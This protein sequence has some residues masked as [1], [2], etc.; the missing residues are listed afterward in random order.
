[1]PLTGVTLPFISYGGSSLVANYMLIALLMRISH[2][3]AQ[4]SGEVKPRKR[5]PRKQPAAVPA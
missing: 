5:S 3:H 2:E 1:V 4:R